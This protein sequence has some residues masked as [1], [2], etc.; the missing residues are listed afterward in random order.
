[1]FNLK[2]EEY[3]INNKNIT[4]LIQPVFY[5]NSHT[6]EEFKKMSSKLKINIVPFATVEEWSYKELIEF[7]LI[8][9]KV[10]EDVREYSDEDTFCFDNGC[11]ECG[12]NVKLNNLIKVDLKEMEKLKAD[13]AIPIKPFYIVSLKFK[14]VFINNKLSGAE[15]LPAKDKKGLISENYFLLQVNSMM[16]PMDKNSL[17]AIPEWEC[18]KCAQ[19][20]YDIKDNLLYNEINM[21][22]TND[23]NITFE[24]FG[25]MEFG[26]NSPLL[27]ISRRTYKAL[28]SKEIKGAYFK[29]VIS[30]A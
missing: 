24:S 14:N 18:E 5:E 10:N 19:T 7:G 15:F 2:C 25:P 17:Q 8:L 22:D 12:S 4:L 1:M 20:G 27:I 16:P 13:I 11:I 30:N 6:H 3:F 28:Y 9:M 23:I 29:P 21:V 26:L